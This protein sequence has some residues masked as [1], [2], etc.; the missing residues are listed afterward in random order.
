MSSYLLNMYVLEITIMY[1][2][3]PG[4]YLLP[5]GSAIKQPLAAFP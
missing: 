4:D 1:L 5:D 3:G 2:H